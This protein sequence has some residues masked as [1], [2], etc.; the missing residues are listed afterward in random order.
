MYQRIIA[1]FCFKIMFVYGNIVFPISFLL[2]SQILTTDIVMANCFELKDQMPK[3]KD[4][5]NKTL[6]VR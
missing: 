2:S 6:P 4:V 5:K 1:D 3:G